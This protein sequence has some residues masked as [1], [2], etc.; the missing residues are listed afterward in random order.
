MIDSQVGLAL[1]AGLILGTRVA[2]GNRSHAG[3]GD[4]WGPWVLAADALSV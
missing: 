3:H 1:E 4:G 2:V